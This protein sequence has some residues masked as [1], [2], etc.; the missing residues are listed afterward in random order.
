MKKIKD[1]LKYIKFKD[2]LGILIFIIIL[3]PSQIYKLYLKIIN[4]KLYLICEN[5]NDAC[6]NGYHL[7]KYIRTNHPNDNFYYAINKKSNHYNKIKDLGNVIQFGSLKHW[8]YYLAA[9]KNI[10]TQ[11]SGNPC[12]TVFYVLHVMFGLFNNRIFLQH[13][14]T[15]DDSPWIYYKATKFKTFVCAARPEYEFIKEKF[16]YPEGYV[17]YLGFPRFDNLI[18]NRTNKKEIVLMPTW[19][20]WL[21]RDINSLGEK[22]DFT[23]TEYYKRFNNLINNKKLIDF[24]EKNDIVLY[25][26]P[27]TNMQKYIKEFKTSSKNVKMLTN[28]EID[29]QELF[30]VPALMITDYSSVSMDFAYMKK[31]ILY[32]QFDLDEYREKQLQQGYY[33]Y[34]KDGFGEIIHDENTLV[35][36][37]IKSYKNNFEMPLKYVERVNNFF[38]L[39]DQNNCKRLYEYI[40]K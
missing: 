1:S 14:I 38:E 11:K 4:K 39:N 23:E 31:P 17:Q 16:G 22:Q 6:D 26:F 21:G 30:I 32:Y 40:I 10:S 36:E 7:F 29:I 19:R 3:I 24:L 2:I 18:N 28:D 15:K 37:I 12:P 34:E 35:E 25:F 8:I 33:S 27:H 9:T 13:G 20:N 5:E